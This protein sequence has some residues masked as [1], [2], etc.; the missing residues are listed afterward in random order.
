MGNL[1]GGGGFCCGNVK[2]VKNVFVQLPLPA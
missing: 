1:K 2:A